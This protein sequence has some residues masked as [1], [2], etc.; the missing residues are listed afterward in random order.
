FASII[1]LEYPVKYDPIAQR[2]ATVAG[3]E[4][5]RNLV[6]LN[7]SSSVRGITQDQNEILFGLSYT[8]LPS[9][10]LSSLLEDFADPAL[11]QLLAPLKDGMDKVNGGLAGSLSEAL[12]G[13]L[14][15]LTRP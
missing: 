11:Q 1:K 3:E 9:I 4:K 8:G 13:P 10:N 7:V 12:R 5:D 6:V 14:E 15:E 2:F